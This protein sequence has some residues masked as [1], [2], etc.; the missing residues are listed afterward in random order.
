VLLAFN[1]WKGAVDLIFGRV[2][3][4]GGQWTTASA[5]FMA[6]AAMCIL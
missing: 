3:G 4:N 2:A 5:A 6:I 1:I